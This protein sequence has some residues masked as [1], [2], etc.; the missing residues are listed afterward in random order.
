MLVMKNKRLN[1]TSVSLAKCALFVVFMVVSA[2]IT[3]PIP[4]VPLTFQTVT[5]VLAGLLLGPRWGG[6]SVAVYIL[7]GLLGL[8]VFAGW[9]G[10]IAY[11]VQLTFGYLLGFILAAII[12]GWLV[13][14]SRR[15]MFRCVVAALYGVIANYCIGILYFSIL[16]THY[17]HYSDLFDAMLTN[18]IYLPKDILLCIAAS[19]LSVRVYPVVRKKS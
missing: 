9:S 19:V 18:L 7:M 12:T 13:G 3:I 14:N 5:A 6:V 10:G 15:T 17:Y 2:Q 8:P 16:W 11:V 4:Y 1:E